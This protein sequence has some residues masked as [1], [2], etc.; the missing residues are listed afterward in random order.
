MR[1]GFVSS[2]DSESMP[3]MTMGYEQAKMLT[4]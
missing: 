3:L 1:F 2:E 4:I